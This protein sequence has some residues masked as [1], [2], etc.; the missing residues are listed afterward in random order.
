M[1]Q[2]VNFEEIRTELKSSILDGAQGA[3]ARVDASDARVVLCI[4]AVIHRVRAGNTSVAC[5]P[6]RKTVVMRLTKGISRGLTGQ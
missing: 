3:K 6:R 5:P 4:G 1:V 2:N